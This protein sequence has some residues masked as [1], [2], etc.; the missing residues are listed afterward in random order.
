MLYTGVVGGILFN[1]KKPLLNPL[2]QACSP[3]TIQ[4]RR[5]S[6]QLRSN[7]GFWK[8]NKTKTK[9][10]RTDT[11]LAHFRR[12]FWPWPCPG[13]RFRYGPSA[14]CLFACVA[15][16]SGAVHAVCLSVLHL[17]ADL[18]AK[19]L[20]PVDLGAGDWKLPT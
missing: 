12:T 18:V 3:P 17:F 9:K 14:A 1:S 15:S 16:R 13:F 6:L 7:C 4:K 2:K 10:K 8:T 11:F 19:D 20:V 5:Q